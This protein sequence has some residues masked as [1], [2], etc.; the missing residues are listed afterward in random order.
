MEQITNLQI[1]LQG[2]KSGYRIVEKGLQTAQELKNG[3]WN[4]HAAYFQ[5]LKQVNPVIA[6]DPKGKAIYGLYQGVVIVFQKEVDWQ[7]Q[8]NLLNRQEFVH[9][10]RVY[11]NLMTES[12]RDLDELVQVLTNGK[13]QLSDQQR[14]ERLDRVYNRMKD[15]YAFAGYFTSQCRKLALGRQQVLQENEQVKQLYGIN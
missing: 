9:L 3:T 10:Q 14:T 1:Y 7:Q 12:Q 5:S 2:L 13:L 8:G 15:K 11:T 4:L 6:A